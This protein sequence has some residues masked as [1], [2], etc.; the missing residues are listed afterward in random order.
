M[1]LTCYSCYNLMANPLL[2]IEGERKDVCLISPKIFLSC[3]MHDSLCLGNSILGFF[4]SY[5]FYHSIEKRLVMSTSLFLRLFKKSII[6]WLG[7][8]LVVI[9][10]TFNFSIWALSCASMQDLVPWPGIET[11]SP[12][13]WVQSF[14]CWT[15]RKVPNT[16]LKYSFIFFCPQ[17]N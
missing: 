6:I 16:N 1:P 10:G 3:A 12:A 11:G 2:I 4:W 9:C 5:N 14:I 7:W 15:T 17:V 13:L 8:V